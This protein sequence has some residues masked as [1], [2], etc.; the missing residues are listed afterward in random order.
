M[1]RDGYPIIANDSNAVL[2]QFCQEITRQR[3]QDVEDFNNLS[4]VFLKGRK[5]AKIPTGSTDTSND[6]IGD[7]NYDT[8]FIY[9]C[10][11]DS[12]TAVWRRVAIGAW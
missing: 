5:V 6:R 1:A 9:V 10:V 11:D 2:K 4:N 3:E 12:G 7:F 8:D